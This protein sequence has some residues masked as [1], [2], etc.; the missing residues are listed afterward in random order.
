MKITTYKELQS[1]DELLPLFLGW[2]PFNPKEFEKAIEA[3]PR[4]RNSPVGYIG[5]QNNHLVGF[6]GVMDIP[7]RTIEGSEEKVGGI[8]GVVTHPGH[9]RKGVFTALMQRSHEY[10]TE[11]GYKFSLLNTSKSLIAYALYKKLGYRDVTVYPSA[12]K[13]IKE[14][15]KT[16]KKESDKK[17]KLDW[18]KILDIYD[19]AT[20]SKTGFVVRDSQYG[21]MLEIRKKIEPEKCVVTDRGYAL[22]REN[23]GN[24][25]IQEIMASTKDE[26]S[27]LISQSERTATK[28]VMAEVVLDSDLL[29]T[30]RSDGFMI[31]EDSY[32]ALM[33]KPLADATFAENYGQR[34]FTTNLDCF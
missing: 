8:W 12:Y 19:Q 31:I 3:D 14:T 21:K 9:A 33:F 5:I 4:L 10:F 27:K 6:V 17:A 13:V 25:A 15:R 26:I 32:D 34:F 22:L 11:K 29:R 28:T 30:Y 1:K 18:S 2:I 16:T 7:T 24:V 20:Q 23:E